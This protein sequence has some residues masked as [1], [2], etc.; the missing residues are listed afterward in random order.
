MLFH[1]A[2][3]RTR[4]SNNRPVLFHAWT[5]SLATMSTIRIV[6]WAVFGCASL[7]TSCA[8]GSSAPSETF[9]CELSG[10]CPLPGSMS[11]HAFQ[12][13]S[14]DSISDVSRAGCCVDLELS[15][16]TVEHHHV[17]QASSGSA[18]VY[19]NGE[20]AKECAAPG[21]C[22][23]TVTALPYGYY[24]VRVVVVVSGSLSASQAFECTQQHPSDPHRCGV[25]T[26]SSQ[27]LNF[28]EPTLLSEALSTDG[29]LHA[30]G[31][32]GAVESIAAVAAAD[33]G[34]D[35]ALRPPGLVI[36]NA[37]QVLYVVHQGV[38]TRWRTL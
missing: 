22:T 32:G 38:R 33:A 24:E 8:A 1:H 4:S 6:S 15:F 29:L 16:Q 11:V 31:D 36:P 35:S 5:G 20:F 12:A 30:V 37:Y 18:M 34:K 2:S 27:K 7:Q 26:Y 17:P 13:A 28:F 19:T 10:T 14:R 23:A 9:P 25:L 3:S 21:L